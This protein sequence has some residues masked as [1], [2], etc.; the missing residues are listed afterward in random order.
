MITRRFFLGS[1]AAFGALGALGKVPGSPALRFGVISDL[2]VALTEKFEVN[3]NYDVKEV[4]HAFAWFRDQKVDAVMIC[5]DIAEGGIVDELK[6][7]ADAWFRVF[8]N[9]RAPDGRRVERLFIYGNHDWDCYEERAKR[10]F[11]DAQER[12]RHILR[13]DFAGHWKRVFGED[14]A[15]IYRKTVKGYDFIGA[16][17]D[18]NAGYRW[19][20]SSS[21]E[22]YFAKIGKTLDPKRPFFYFQHSHLK[23]TCYGPWAWGH[24]DGQS[25]RALSA[26]PNA[27]AISGHSHYT[28]TDE[29]AIW[30]GAF[31][32]IAASSMHDAGFPADELYPVGYENTYACDA[33]RRQID[34]EKLMGEFRPW[35][36]KQ[37]LL[38]D[39]YADRLEIDRRDFRT[40]CSLGAEWIVPLPVAETKPYSFAAQTKR[41]A[42]PVWRDGAKLKVVR[43]KAKN[44]AGKEKDVLE[45][46]IPAPVARDGAR[47][48]RFEVTVA[49]PGFKRVKYVLA[50]GFNQASGNEWASG[51]TICRFA[52]DDLPTGPLIVSVT[53]ENCFYR[54]GPALSV[55]LI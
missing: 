12:T 55:N 11:P 13:N 19:N 48:Y 2:H 14:Y 30:Q 49:A 52:A 7:V 22:G 42:V 9:D 8:P 23:D 37:G 38:V 24:D 4:E 51:S 3:P 33:V 44:R 31:T 47:A 45:V 39:V 6:V 20:G 10:M 29:R 46:K 16:H 25:T 53:P 5:G 43:T 34:A 40:D 41:I 50:E 54:R 28:L 1:G 21:V 18:G 36:H 27:V 15:P 17:W 35:G 32:S 26:F